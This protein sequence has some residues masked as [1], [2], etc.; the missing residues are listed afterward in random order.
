MTPHGGLGND[1]ITGG[2]GDPG[3]PGLG[4]DEGDD[5]FYGGDGNDD[6]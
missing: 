4:S 6:E 2:D 1:V 3:A 5:V